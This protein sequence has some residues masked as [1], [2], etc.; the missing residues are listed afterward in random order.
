MEDSLNVIDSIEFADLFV[1][2]RERKSMD[3]AMGPAW[4]ATAL[5]VGGEVRLK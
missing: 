2:I 3:E 1:R 5:G 4:Q